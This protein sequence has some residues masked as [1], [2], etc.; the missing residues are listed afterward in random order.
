MCEDLSVKQLFS[1]KIS[2][3]TRFNSWATEHHA[4][5]PQDLNDEP[6]F[7]AVLDCLAAIVATDDVILCHNAGYDIGQVL[8]P[9]CRMQGLDGAQLLDLPRV[10]TCKRRLGIDCD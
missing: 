6:E 10:C 1:S 4:S 7:K 8:A 9:M 5:T 3:A 2:G